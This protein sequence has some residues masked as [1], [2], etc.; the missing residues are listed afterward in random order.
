LDL[1]AT[2]D[3]E[4]C[5]N[6]V[7]LR[8]KAKNLVGELDCKTHYLC[9]S[10]GG[11]CEEISPIETIKISLDEEEE[12]IKQEIVK[13]IEDEIADCW[14]MFGEGKLSYGS[15]L[16]KFHCA[17]CTIFKFDNKIQE[18]YPKIE[19]NGEEILTSEKYAVFTGIDPKLGEETYIEA[20]I[21]L[22]KDIGDE[23]KSGCNVF[24]ITQA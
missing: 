5:H 23:D 6:S 3:K 21:I 18:E 8:S 19:F 20:Q 13:A 7:V 16:G 22:S 10:G 11:N 4:I 12:I 14:W 1:G 9:I 24:D 17:I 2:T 15:F